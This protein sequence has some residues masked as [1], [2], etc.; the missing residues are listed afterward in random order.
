MA[1]RL[2]VL[3]PC[4]DERKN[5]R[6]CIESVRPLADE[7]LVAD[8]GSTD[9]TLDVVRE[10]GGCRII[11]R[12]YRYSADFKNWAIPQ[13]KHPWVLLVDADERVTDKLADSIRR[14]LRNPPPDRDAYW[15]SFDCYFLGH[16]LKYCGWNTKAIRLFRRDTCRYEDRLVHADIEVD[17]RRVGWLKGKF[18]HYSIWSYDQFL[19]KYARYTTWGAQTLHRRGRRATFASLLIRPMLRFVSLYFLR[20]GFLDGLPGLQACMLT[21]YYNTFVKQGK[22]WELT[23]VAAPPEHEPP[24]ATRTDRAA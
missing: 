6:A 7:I 14:V 24:L 19:A 1:E 2:T 23:N 9:G 4:K 5:I 15:A 13:A 21:A 17:R 11:E 22:L 10:M 8:S 3:I 20:G 18:L 12:E 16:R